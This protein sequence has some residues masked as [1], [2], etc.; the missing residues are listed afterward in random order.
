[1]SRTTQPPDPQPDEWY[2]DGL[3]FSCTQCGNCCTG[4]TGYVFFND[5]EAAAMAKALG[6]TLPDFYRQYTRRVGN[7]LSLNETRSEYGYDCVFLR[8]DAEG[9][10][11]CSVYLARP[12]QCKTWPFW[13][14][15]LTSKRA[16]AAVARRCPGVTE[17]NKGNGTF[18]PIEQ[19]R[20]LRDAEV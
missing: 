19:V 2:A 12:T 1:M 20:I 13:P 16:Y 15:N 11:L 4:P 7:R 10:A 5:A 9:K 17:G 8:R 14:E 6:I 18:Y 3:R